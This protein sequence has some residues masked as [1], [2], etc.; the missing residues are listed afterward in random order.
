MASNNVIAILQARMG[1]ERCPGKSMEL[2]GGVPVV[3]LVLRRL[4]GAKELSKV[5]LATSDLDRDTVLAETAAKAGFDVF[6]GSETDLVGRFVAAAEKYQAG[7]YILRATGDNVF[8]DPDLVD[9]QL[10]TAMDGGYDFVGWTNDQWPERQNDFAGEAIRLDA[11]K[12]VAA[13]TQD[14][15]DREHVYPYF[16]KHPELFK[17]HRIPVPQSHRS[18]VKLDLD[19]FEDL[20][21]MKKIGERL[22]DPVKASTTEIIAIANAL[23]G[24]SV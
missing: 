23:S 15:F 9:L 4:S 13:A 14:A 10:H 17:V 20:E 24:V 6:R 12:A 11:L 8:M 16:N 5:I 21:L 1:S 18:P 19:Y 2:I 22:A 3:E 7:P